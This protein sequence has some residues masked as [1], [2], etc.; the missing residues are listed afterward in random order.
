MSETE[1]GS[2][3]RDDGEAPNA[4]FG[5]PFLFQIIRNYDF[6]EKSPEYKSQSGY[7]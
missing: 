3:P 2:S 1:L 6:L 5:F 7:T 4:I